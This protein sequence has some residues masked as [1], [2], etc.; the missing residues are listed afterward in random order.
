MYAA[1]L[2]TWVVV[3]TS[4]KTGL[5]LG[6]LALF[7]AAT[8]AFAQTS[9]GSVNNLT[10]NVVVVRGSETYTLSPKDQLFLGDRILTRSDGVASISANGCVKDLSSLQSIVVDAEF[11][12]KTP[13]ALGS[14]ATNVASGGVLGTGVGATPAILGVLA[15]GGGAAAAAGGGGSSS[16]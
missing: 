5:A 12:T 11:C 2:V 4:F 3:M 16:P 6:A 13:I 15:L 9:V 14:E 7:G 10:G 8:A 1:A